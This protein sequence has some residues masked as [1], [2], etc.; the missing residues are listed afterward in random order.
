M[1]E[2]NITLINI[3]LIGILI[4]G[5]GSVMYYVSKWKMSKAFVLILVISTIGMLLCNIIS[6]PIIP[7]EFQIL[8]VIV[9]S[10]L[11]WATIVEGSDRRYYL[12]GI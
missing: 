10:A 3:T 11:L 1:V 7:T 5:I 8:I 9:T 2:L 6:L 4:G 12:K